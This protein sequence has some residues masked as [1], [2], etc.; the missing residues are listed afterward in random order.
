M[1]EVQAP[2]E[3][4]SS[5]KKSLELA[6]SYKDRDHTSCM[7]HCRRSLEAVVSY[8]LIEKKFSKEAIPMQ[9]AK[10]IKFLELERPG[11]YF[12]INRITSRWIHWSPE[13]TLRQN[14]LDICISLMKKVLQEVFEITNDELS[15][16]YSLFDILKVHFSGKDRELYLKA[17]A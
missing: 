6:I 17:G 11:K 3:A 14:E 7:L 13:A 5:S 1:V 10:Q 8:L 9:L 12:K 2:I 16:E 4:R 15:E